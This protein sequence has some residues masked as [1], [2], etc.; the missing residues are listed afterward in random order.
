MS[1]HNNRPE[2]AFAHSKNY[3]TQKDMLLGR[4]YLIDVLAKVNDGRM[5]EITC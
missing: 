4:D 5:I 2:V 1:E 3:L